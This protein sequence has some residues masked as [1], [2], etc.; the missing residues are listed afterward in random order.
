M[1]GCYSFSNISQHLAFCQ[2]CDI[3]QVQE[4]LQRVLISAFLVPVVMMSDVTARHRMGQRKAFKMTSL[5]IFKIIFSTFALHQVPCA[6]LC[7]VYKDWTFYCYFFHWF[8]QLLSLQISKEKPTL[9]PR[10]EAEFAN[11][12][13]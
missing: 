3:L 11:F 6:R 4:M 2:V 1:P 9:N 10:Y 13:L 7:C 12:T 8:V 5:L